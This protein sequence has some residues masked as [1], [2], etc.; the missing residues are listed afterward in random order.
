MRPPKI[1]FRFLFYTPKDIYLKKK[2][3]IHFVNA[4]LVDKYLIL[5]KKIIRNDQSVIFS[6]MQK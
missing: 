2:K 6:A 3:C 4:Y 5:C 1:D